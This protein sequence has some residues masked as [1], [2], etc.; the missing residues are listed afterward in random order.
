MKRTDYRCPLCDKPLFRQWGNQTHPG[1]KEF[2]V[3]LFCI[4]GDP[5]ARNHPQEVS[6]HGNGRSEESMMK[7][8][9]AVIQARFCGAKLDTE[10]ELQEIAV[11]EVET[12]P[13]PTISKGKRK[14]KTVMPVVE[15]EDDS[16]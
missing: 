4:N 13:A 2:G 9:Y 10:G 15:E 8:A 5:D 11:D 14:A 7:N 3:T 12:V 1:D 16:I 6:G